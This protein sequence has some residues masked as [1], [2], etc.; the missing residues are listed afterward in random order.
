MKPGQTKT[1]DVV[2]FSE[3][4]LPNDVQLVVG[5]HIRGD[6]NPM[7]VGPIGTGI[8]PT[9]EPMS[10]HN[11]MHVTFT[12]Q[13]DPST[14]PGDYPFVVRSILNPGDSHNWPVI[15]RVL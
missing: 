13:V 1:L 14:A 4:K 11:G 10:G 6:Q 15:L 3:K 7:D 2:I 9:L 12:L 8:T 5:A